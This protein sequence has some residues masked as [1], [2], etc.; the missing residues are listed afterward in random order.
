ME[1]RN[2]SP[3]EEIANGPA[4]WL[5][6]YLRRSG[7]RGFFLP[8]SGGGDSSAV[9]CIVASMAMLLFKEIQNGNQSVLDDIR[10]V[11]RDS[12]FMPKSFKCIV[13]QLFVTSYLG[14]SLTSDESL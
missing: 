8:L 14:N 3:E 1:L 2:Y 9:A 4:L 11:V 6:D 12:S 13:G 10:R 5:W 7:G